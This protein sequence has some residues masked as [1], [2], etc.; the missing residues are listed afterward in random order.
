MKILN[1]TFNFWPHNYLPINTEHYEKSISEISALINENKQ[2]FDCLMEIN[3][4]I[5]EFS[6]LT[7]NIFKKHFIIPRFD[8]TASHIRMSLE[9]LGMKS[10]L[11]A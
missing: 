1:E 11:N 6:I 5:G 7:R 10:K 8:D 3:S 9:E 2:K 4:A